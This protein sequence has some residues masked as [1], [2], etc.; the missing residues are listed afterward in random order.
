MEVG[1]CQKIQQYYVIIKSNYVIV[2][3]KLCGADENDEHIILCNYHEKSFI[4][5]F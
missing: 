2:Q 4:V 1:F 3:T 5:T